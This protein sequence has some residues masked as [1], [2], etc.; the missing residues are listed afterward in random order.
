MRFAWGPAF[1]G[2]LPGAFTF[3]MEAGYLPYRQFDF[4]RAHLHFGN[5]SGAAYGQMSLNAHF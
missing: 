5:E 3:E 1:L 4:E 2:R